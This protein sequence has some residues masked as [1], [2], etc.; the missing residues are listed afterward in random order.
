MVHS[1]EHQLRL[2]EI[3][4][5]IESRFADELK[6]A[7]IIRGWLLRRKMQAAMARERSQIEPSDLAL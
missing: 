5:S 3:R 1:P 7:G 6:S 2:A 4:E